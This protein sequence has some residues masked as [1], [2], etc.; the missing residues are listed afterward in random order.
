[1]ESTGIPKTIVQYIL[2]MIWKKEG[3]ACA[4]FRTTEQRQQ[5]MSYDKDVW[6]MI[7]NDPDFVDSIITG[8]ESRCFSY[9]DLIKWQSMSELVQNHHVWKNFTSKNPKIKTIFIV[10]L[11]SKGVVHKEFVLERQTV[12]KEF[13]LKVLGCLLKWNQIFGAP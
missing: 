2:R 6:E 1:M 5:Q 11:C 7:A 10:F 3:R 13:Y 8:D 4:S 12:T 9:D